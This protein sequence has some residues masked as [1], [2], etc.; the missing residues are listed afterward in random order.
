[1]GGHVAEKLVIGKGKITS[2]CSS[3]LRGAT[4][5]ATQAVRTSG[6]FG[7]MASL[8]S[9]A[10]DENSDKYNALV[11]SAVKKILDVSTKSFNHC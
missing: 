5:Y 8:S 1:M 3:D 4:Q 11:D 10:F 7:D 9:T 2:G 6:M